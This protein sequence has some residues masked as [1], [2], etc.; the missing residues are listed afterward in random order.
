MVL[1]LIT[2]VRSPKPGVPKVI[3]LTSNPGN[4]GH[5]WHKRWF[6]RPTSEELGARPLPQPFEVWRPLP[7]KDDP[8][9]P[10]QI[11]T[12]Q[13]IPAWFHDNLALQ[14]ADPNYLAKVWALGGDKAKQLAEGDWDAN[15]SMIVGAFW[16]ERH[17]ILATDAALLAHAA[18]TPIRSSRGTSSPMRSW[19][20]PVG[21]KIYGSVDYGFGA[22]WSFH[23]HATLPGGHTRTFFEFYEAGVRD[24]EQAKRIWRALNELTFATAKIPLLEGLE[25]IVYEP[26]MAARGRKSGSRSRSS[27]SIRTRRNTRC[28][29]SRAPAAGRRACHA[30]TAGWMRCRSRRTAS[31]GGPA[32]R[33]VRT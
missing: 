23:L 33:R 24:H 10:D 11:L 25:Y 22:P 9:P 12:R 8:T 26:M 19:R 15:E 28:S 1:Y 16:R 4:V 7:K 17:R 14:T 29:S 3:R 5:G 20:P 21:S 31:R 18:C 2:R 6:I 30:R 32:P 13:F 27:R